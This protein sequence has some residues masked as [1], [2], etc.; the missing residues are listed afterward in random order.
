MLENSIDWLKL[1]AGETTWHSPAQQLATLHAYGFA[2]LVH[3]QFFTLV[4][5]LKLVI[6]RLLI[7]KTCYV[8][9]HSLGKY[10]LPRKMTVHLLRI[11]GG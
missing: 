5:W 9:I 11:P 7:Y 3:G 6:A 10:K 8:I 1:A 4:N 2:F